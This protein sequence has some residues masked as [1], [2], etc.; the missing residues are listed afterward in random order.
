V[1]SNVGCIS[2][3]DLEVTMYNNLTY[4]AARARDDELRR[5]WS[6]PDRVLALELQRGRR[7]RRP[8]R[9]TR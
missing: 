8:S 2:H 1:A 6:R 7:S 9:R 4:D 3:T 5:T